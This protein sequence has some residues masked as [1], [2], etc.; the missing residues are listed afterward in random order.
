MMVCSFALPLWEAEMIKRTLPSHF[1]FLSIFLH[2]AAVMCSVCAEEGM[3]RS[4]W[5]HH[6][7][8]GRTQVPPGLALFV[9]MKGLKDQFSSAKLLIFS[10]PN[11]GCMRNKH[12][13]T[14]FSPINFSILLR[15]CVSSHAQS[16]PVN[17]FFFFFFLKN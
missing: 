4:W 12:F 14:Q 15:G 9:P 13:A 16:S 2:K 17:L 8:T 7:A 5:S 1:L 3:T 6:T 10:P 11:E